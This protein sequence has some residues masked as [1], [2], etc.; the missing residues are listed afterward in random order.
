MPGLSKAISNAAYKNG[1]DA[2]G[3][4]LDDLSVIIESK[5]VTIIGADNEA[6]VHTL[7]KWIRERCPK[8]E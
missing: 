3:F 4:H 6:K 7:M 8:G 1:G 5:R 2:L